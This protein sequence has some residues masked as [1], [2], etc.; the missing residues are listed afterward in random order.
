VVHGLL[1]E[2]AME[3]VSKAVFCALVLAATIKVVADLRV[4]RRGATARAES[5]APR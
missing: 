3:T 5:V 1:I 4:W 2:G